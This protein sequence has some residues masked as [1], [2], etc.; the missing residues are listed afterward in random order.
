M[1]KMKDSNRSFTLQNRFQA[2]DRSWSYSISGLPSDSALNSKGHIKSIS[3]VSDRLKQ[4]MILRFDKYSPNRAIDGQNLDKYISISF[5]RFRLQSRTQASSSDSQENEFQPA[6]AKESGDYI[7]RL[8]RTGICLNGVSYHFFGHSNSQLKSKTC[9]LYAGTAEEAAR[10]VEALADFPKK[11]V[12]K[13][14]KRVG[15]LFSAAKFAANLASDRCEDIAD[16]RKDD[17]IFTDGCGL[18]SPHFAKLLVQKTDIRFRNLRYTPAVFQ[19][20]YRG[21][22]GVL[23][24]HPELR[25]QILVKFRESMKKFGGYH[26]PAFSVVEYSKPY[27][28]GFLNDE[29]VLLLNGLG[30]A[31]DTIAGKLREYLDFLASV[32]SDPRA[33]F[34]FFSYNDEP[35]LAEKVLMDGIDTVKSTAQSRV[36]NEISKLLN[37]R[38]ERRARILIPQSRLL[39]GVCDP[40]GVLKEG[41]CFVRV[42]SDGDGAPKTVVGI[43][44]LVTRN[45]CLHPGDLQKFRAVQ[46]TCLS[47]LV[48]CIVFPTT[49]RRPS[50][51]LMSGGDLDGDKCTSAASHRVVEI[52]LISE[53]SSSPGIKV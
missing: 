41:E 11:S 17:Y 45:P 37:K 18:I 7:V 43:E 3:L 36:S 21:Y 5:E 6:S 24:L 49:G 38:G 25:G 10:K 1:S 32:P 12:A 22:K 31:E 15:L 34:R 40:F 48:D 26:D 29:I 46:H 2:E 28:F 52:L 33:A 30:I 35:E 51:D 27:G 47:H 50:A 23:T 42:T 53:Q 9:F 20:R 16:I 14:A 44:V 13:S 19:I 4:S 39:F 8:L